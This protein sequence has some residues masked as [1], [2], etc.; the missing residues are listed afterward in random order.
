MSR[1]RKVAVRIYGD[2]RFNAL[3]RFV[4]SGQQ[5]YFYL[6]TG[7]HTTILP[8]LFEAGPWSI[9]EKLRWSLEDT[10]RCFEEILVQEMV[11]FDRDALVMWVPNLIIDNLP[12]NQNVLTSWRR[13]WDELPSSLLKYNFLEELKYVLDQEDRAV[14]KRV[15]EVFPELLRWGNQPLPQPLGQRLREPLTKPLPQRLTQ[16]L[17]EPLGELLLEPFG[18]TGTGAGTG[19]KEKKEKEKKEKRLGLAKPQACRKLGSFDEFC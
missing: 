8:G 14:M 1:Y 12:A 17:P 6:I 4:P 18:N 9:A 7:P 19:L 11:H 2:K 13:A 15:V 16:R 10:E 5:L 3:S